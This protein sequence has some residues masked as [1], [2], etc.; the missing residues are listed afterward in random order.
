MAY[1]QRGKVR[2]PI[3]SLDLY[4]LSGAFQLSA[5][6]VDIASPGTANK[7]GNAGTGQDGLKLQ[8]AVVGRS[9]EGKVR[10]GIESNQVDLGAQAAPQLHHLAGM[11]DIIVDPAQ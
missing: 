3:S 6:G 10:A 1:G 7:A 11:P 5:S 2:C 9:G 8:H 4:H